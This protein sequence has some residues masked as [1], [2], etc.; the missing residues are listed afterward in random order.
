VGRRRCTDTERRR[1]IG[2][3]KLFRADA[4]W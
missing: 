3:A 4:F 1:G 2:L